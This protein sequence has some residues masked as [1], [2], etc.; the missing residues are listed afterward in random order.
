MFLLKKILTA[1][2]VPRFGLI[3][4]YTLGLWISRRRPKV[5][6]TSSL[7]ALLL[8]TLLSLPYVSGD[9]VANSGATWPYQHE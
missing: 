1:L 3:L 5:G 9:T 8:L 2:V 6:H 7:F 4:L